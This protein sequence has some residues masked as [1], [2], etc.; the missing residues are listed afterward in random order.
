MRNRSFLIQRGAVWLGGAGGEQLHCYVAPQSMHRVRVRGRV[1]GEGE[2]G[3][4]VKLM[5]GE[6][7]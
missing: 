4:G 6:G 1:P 2:V 7:N 3:E 5:A